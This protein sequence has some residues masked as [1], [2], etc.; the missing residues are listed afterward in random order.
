M[1][2]HN[3]RTQRHPGGIPQEPTEPCADPLRRRDSWPTAWK[4]QLAQALGAAEAE[5]LIADILT[6]EDER[7]RQFEIAL[8]A[9]VSWDE[10]TA[11]WGRIGLAQPPPPAPEMPLCFSER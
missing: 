2:D 11:L 9:S 8:L 3:P 1:M 5:K 7:R 4:Q 6:A 10:A